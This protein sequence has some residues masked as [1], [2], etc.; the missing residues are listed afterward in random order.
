MLSPMLGRRIAATVVSFAAFIGIWWAISA[1]EIVNPVFFPAPPLVLSAA[2]EMLEGGVL[3]SD[4]QV[5]L[6]R[7]AVGFVAG[8]VLGLLTGLLTSR[9]AFFNL[10]LNPLLSLC[11]PIP[12]IALVPVAIVWFGIGETSKYFVIGYSVFL[13]VWLNTHHGMS[14]VAETYVRASRS[15]GASRSREFVEVIIPAASPYIMA[16]IRSAAAVA[17]LCL[18]AAELTGASGGIGYRLQESRQYI[19]VDRMFVSLIE[20][21]LL[22]ALL[23]AIFVA[24]GRR[25]IHWEQM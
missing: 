15:L 9:M 24:I 22:G 7:A 6:G 12:A 21:G 11:R 3:F 23:D 2:L 4:L 17:F 25:V 19:R 14:M 5:S 10:M 1:L 18:V 20:L 16:G 13:T 8:V